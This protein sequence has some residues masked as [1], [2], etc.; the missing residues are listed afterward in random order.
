[1]SGAAVTIER[2]TLRDLAELAPLFTAYRQFYGRPD[3]PRARSFLA[4]RLERSESIVFVARRAGKAL[5]FTQLYPT[6]ASVALTRMFVLYDLFVA[7]AGR[8]SGAGAALLR[9][10]VEHAAHAGAGFLMLQ[11]ATTNLAAQ[12]LYEREGWVRDR[13]FYVYEYHL[14]EAKPPP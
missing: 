3:D 12:R 11:T 7:P 4:E 9:A 8:R 6:F 1:M 10:A 2:A 14:P 5:G 13:D